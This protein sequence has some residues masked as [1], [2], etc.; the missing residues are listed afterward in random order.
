[1]KRYLHIMD[2]AFSFNTDSQDPLTEDQI[3]Q[4]IEAVKERL[5]SIGRSADVEAFGINET[6][7][8]ESDQ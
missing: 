5:R 8:R 7:D 1:M 4:I 3:P 2:L 6:V